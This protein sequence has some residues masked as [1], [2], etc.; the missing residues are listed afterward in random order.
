MDVG[1]GGRGLPGRFGQGGEEIQGLH[2]DG[3][4]EIPPGELQAANLVAG[5]DPERGFEILGFQRA[6]EFRHQLGRNHTAGFAIQFLDLGDIG[7]G[8]GEK[9]GQ[10]D[11]LLRRDRQRQRSARDGGFFGNHMEARQQK[12]H[13]PPRRGPDFVAV[14]ADR[15][16]LAEHRRFDQDL[17]GKLHPR[18]ERRAF[19]FLRQPPAHIAEHQL[20]LGRA[21]RAVRLRQKHSQKRL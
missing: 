16:L 15:E 2:I 12:F 17:V 4:A 18:L 6:G 7:T 13:L 10:E 1:G 5:C 19:H 11:R 14:A 20:H 3:G 9:R 8:H 21:V